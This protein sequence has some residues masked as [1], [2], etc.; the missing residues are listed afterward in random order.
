MTGESTWTRP[1][2]PV[3]PTLQDGW[4]GHG[5]AEGR[6]YYVNASTGESSWTLPEDS[7]GRTFYAN[8][9]TGDASWERPSASLISVAAPIISKEF[10]RR[11]NNDDS[12]ETKGT[13][14]SRLNAGYSERRTKSMP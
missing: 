6:T 8:F 10:G 13:L 4:D 7:E 1:E 12:T 14:A 11:C 3:V 5:D 9:A 2:T